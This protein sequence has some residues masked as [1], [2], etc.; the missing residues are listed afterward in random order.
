MSISFAIAS[1]TYYS[2]GGIAGLTT[3]LALT[4]FSKERHDIKLDVYEAATQFTEIGAG[5]GFWPRPWN[6][7]KKLG[8]TDDLERLLEN[9]PKEGELGKDSPH[10]RVII[11][12]GDSHADLDR[13]FSQVHRTAEVRF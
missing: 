1:H 12:L 10:I 3:A 5:I 2:G 8:C 9:Q 13:A 11:I 4:H 7:L 6:I